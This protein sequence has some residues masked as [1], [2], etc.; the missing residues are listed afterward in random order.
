M[1]TELN[2]IKSI[3]TESTNTVFASYISY[4]NST[5]IINALKLTSCQSERI[6][7]GRFGSEQSCSECMGG[8]LDRELFSTIL[9]PGERSS[10]F[11]AS[12]NSLSE[13]YEDHRIMFFYIN[14]N[15][16]IAR[17]E[18]PQWIGEN[19]K[20]LEL[21]HSLILDQCSKGK[22]YPVSLMEAH[23]QAVVTNADR[24]TFITMIEKTL[25]LSLIHI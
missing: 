5:D 15:N 14:V 17:I 13:Y 1:V 19:S 8:V 23:E 21:L 25:H 4:P 22:G 16:E 24:K 18:I 12:E 9:S 10:V 7:C 2:K 11:Y 3:I 6:R 20:L